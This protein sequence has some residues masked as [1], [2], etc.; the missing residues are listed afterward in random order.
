MSHQIL[1]GGMSREITYII[2]IFVVFCDGE[3]Y[4]SVHF[5]YVKRG[6]HFIFLR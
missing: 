3:R 2:V 1:K 5:Y 4:L 6:L